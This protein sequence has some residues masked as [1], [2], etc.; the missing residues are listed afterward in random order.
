MNILV[1]CEESGRVTEEFR[2][3]GHNAFSCDILKTSGNYPEYHI[4]G[5]VLPYINNT[6][7]GHIF[8]TQDGKLHTIYK[9]D[10]LIA[11]PPCTYMSKAGARH[12]YKGG[13]INNE[14]L[15]KAVAAKEFFMKMYTSN[16]DRICIENPT[17]LK[18]VD[19]PLHS[20]VIQP[21]QFGHPFSKR[22]LLWL[23]NLPELLPTDIITNYKTYLPSNTG[24]IKR[25]Q[26]SQQGNANTAKE[27]SK[28]FVG[29]A[30]AM[31]QQWG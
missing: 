3:K 12:M 28:T 7:D 25:G 31:A 19:L 4:V 21:Y 29:I 8:E 11:F 14:R 24:G 15:E 23:K 22:T 17:P 1:A 6:E 13:Y 5:D 16:I 9:W 20:Q 30:T 18:V 10:M 2:K 26:N 27:R